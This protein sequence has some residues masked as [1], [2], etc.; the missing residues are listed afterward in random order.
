[1]PSNF[2]STKVKVDLFNDINMLLMAEKYSRGRIR[3]F[4]CWYIKTNNKNMKDYD[5]HRESSYIQYW[6][7]N[8]LHG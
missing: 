4:I 7:E 6:H 8:N 5:K 3:H 1:M 2:K